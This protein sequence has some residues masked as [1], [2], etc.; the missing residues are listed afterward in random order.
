ME[1]WGF[2]FFFIQF[3]IFFVFSF[4]F[5]LFVHFSTIFRKY[6]KKSETKLIAKTKRSKIIANCG[7]SEN[8]C[9]GLVFYR[10]IC[11]KVRKYF[12]I[13]FRFHFFHFFLGFVFFC[14]FIFLLLY[15]F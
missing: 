5:F 13:C 6:L 4:L 12:K 2:L 1:I 8:K 9:V 11:D 3:V 10:I 7:V 14:I 15:Y